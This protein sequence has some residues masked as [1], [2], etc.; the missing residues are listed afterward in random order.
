MPEFHSK[1][2]S[3]KSASLQNKA[4]TSDRSQSLQNHRADIPKQESGF[5]PVQMRQRCEFVF[6]DCEHFL[7]GEFDR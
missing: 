3:P 2:P 6:L 5:A 7:I 4:K 1:S